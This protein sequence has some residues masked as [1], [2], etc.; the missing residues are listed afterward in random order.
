VIWEKLKKKKMGKKTISF[1]I[2]FFW[3]VLGTLMQISAYPRYNFLNFDYNSFVFNLL[4]FITLPFNILVFGLLFTEKFE[5]IYLVVIILQT[6][7]IF[8]Y[9]WIIYRILE[10]RKV[11]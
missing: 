1:I 11:K 5:N 9:W 6:I 7:K 8:L 3:I 2:S 10:R 4:Y